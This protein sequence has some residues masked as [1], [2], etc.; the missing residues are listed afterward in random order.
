MSQAISLAEAVSQLTAAFGRRQRANGNA[1]D[2]FFFMIGAGMSAPAIPLAGEI[3][4]HCRGTLRQEPD[5]G[6]PRAAIDRYSFWLERAFPQPIERQELFRQLIER[7]PISPANFRLAHL[8]SNPLIPHLVV[9]TNFDD[10]LSRALAL[11]GTA[12]IVS[13]HPETAERIDPERSSDVQILHVHG[14]YWFYDCCNLRAEIAGRAR[15]TQ[16][17][18]TMASRL[19]RILDRRSPIVIGY[20]G[21]EDDVFMTALRQ[22]IESHALAYNL[23]WFCHDRAGA[24]LLPDWLLGCTHVRFVVPADTGDGAPGDRR[25]AAEQEPTLAAVTILDAL[26]RALEMPVPDLTRNPVAFFARHLRTSLI[27]TDEAREST[28]DDVYLLEA[29]IEELELLAPSWESAGSRTDAAGP[30]MQLE[31]IRDAVRRSRYQEAI[32]S[33]RAIDL[34]TLPATSVRE[35]REMALMAALQ[36][37]DDSDDELDGYRLAIAA[38]DRFQ[39]D[40]PDLLENARSAVSAFANAATVL[41]AQRRDGEAVEMLT[42]AF[43]RFEDIPE[44][45]PDVVDLLETRALVLWRTRQHPQELE[46]WDLIIKRFAEDS[47]PTV[48]ATVARAY[49]EK[50]DTLENDDYP[51]ALMTYDAMLAYYADSPVPAVQVEVVRAMRARAFALAML[52]RHAEAVTTIDELIATWEH[53]P[54]ARIR[55]ELARAFDDKAFDLQML[56]R[57]DEAISTLDAQQDRYGDDP[58][59]QTEVLAGRLSKGR[60]LVRSGRRDDAT[61]IFD[62]IIEQGRGLPGAARYVERARNERERLS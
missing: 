12:H 43:L 45:R 16:P 59:L 47:D 25:A 61:A 20:S 28:A 56:G 31:A 57:I 44:L 39:G 55:R 46:T 4:E 9:T 5:V 27:P 24:E 34:E 14:T 50:A 62:A 8:L 26:I 21:W 11:F 15:E 30:A 52:Q 13:D 41:T 58:E 53:S 7:R 36:L 17:Y 35:L 22:R 48:Q 1:S 42:E 54:S 49:V 6:V 60:L 10:F 38:A 29:M 18:R 2:A 3:E 40:G 23:Y 51:A 32:V 37:D 33:A 19:D